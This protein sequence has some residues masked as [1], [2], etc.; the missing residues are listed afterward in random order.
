MAAYWVVI[1]AYSAN[2]LWETHVKDAA[3]QA[4]QAIYENQSQG[5]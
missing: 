5:T 1:T 2:D 4:Q 3:R